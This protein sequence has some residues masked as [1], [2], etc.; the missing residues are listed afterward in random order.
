MIQIIGGDLITVEATLNPFD[1][2][3]DEGATCSEYTW[4]KFDFSKHDTVHGHAVELDIDDHSDDVTVSGDIVDLAVKG[5]YF[6]KYVCST[7]RDSVDVEKTRTVVVADRTCPSC[8]VVGQ[9]MITI[10]ASFPYEDASTSC[11]DNFDGVLQRTHHAIS[12][13]GAATSLDGVDVEAAGMYRITYTATDESG[14][15]AGT[16]TNRHTDTRNLPVRT[17]V[18]IDTLKPV[19]GLRYRGEQFDKDTTR[20]IPVRSPLTGQH[21]PS[22]NANGD[23]FSLMA[24][25]LLRSWWGKSAAFACV[26][27]L[28]VVAVAVM[29]HQ[30]LDTSS[31]LT[32][33]DCHV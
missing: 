25:P 32:T 27:G 4:D 7:P 11:S 33:S 10:E 12:L 6:V 26:A 5:T 31:L 20:S 9:S 2:Y 19:I 24:E 1:E 23:Y 22:F 30:N 3:V 8:K 15:V 17:V 21:N 28:V 14:N 16:C 13:N 18:V 29:H